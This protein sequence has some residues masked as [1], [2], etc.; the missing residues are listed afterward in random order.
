MPKA[1]I[2]V[3]LPGIPLYTTSNYV[4]TARRCSLS[5]ATAYALIFPQIY[6]KTGCSWHS[7]ALCC[8]K[9]QEN[10]NDLIGFCKRKGRREGGRERGGM[11]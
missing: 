4:T 3:E 7:S 6:V 8:P 10:Q 5:S 11:E 9:I 2:T 1:I